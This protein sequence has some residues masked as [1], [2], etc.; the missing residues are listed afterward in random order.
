[1]HDAANHVVFGSRTATSGEVTRFLDE[2]REG[3][4]SA[5]DRIFPLVYD[6]LQALARRQLG[7]CGRPG[8]TLETTAVVHE[9]YLKLSDSGSAGWRDRR[10]F[11]AVAA[12][13]MRQIL[14]DHVRRASA[15][16]R[17]GSRTRAVS[18]SEELVPA[19]PCGEAL[20]ALREAVDE[21]AG[22]EPRLARIV[23]LRFYA[24]LSVEETAKAMRL[25]PRTV[26]RDWRRARALLYDAVRADRSA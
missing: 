2:L 26:K 17:G 22:R 6:E 23:N 24:G 9:T 8:D 14:L 10:H 7:C 3:D 21:L 13:A 16:K 20:L 1:M 5:L 25:S 11:F 15:E 18:L 4:H 12:R 19:P